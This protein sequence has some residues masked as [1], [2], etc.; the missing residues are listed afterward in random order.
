MTWLFL[1]VISAIL[2]GLSRVFQKV[3]LK[4]NDSDAFAFSFTFQILVSLF[5]LGY[6][7]ITQSFEVPNLNG[8]LINIV[9]MG[10][11]SRNNFSKKLETS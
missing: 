8:L 3:L 5:L 11:F 2:L 7:L 4:D 9:I 6:S 10:T 1:T